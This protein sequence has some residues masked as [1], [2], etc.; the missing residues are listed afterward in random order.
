MAVRIITDSTADLVPEL[1]S[2]VTVVPM[3]ISFGP[4]EY[5]DGA[6]F[7]PRDFYEKLSCSPHHP[8][9]SQPAPAA[10]EDVFSQAVAAGDQ[11]VAITISREL[12]GTFQSAT[13]AA[14]AYPEE[15][16]VV[17][18]RTVAL[19]TG[20]LV[21]LALQLVDQGHTAPQI[22]QALTEA[23]ERLVILAMVDTL[24]YLKRGGRISKAAAVAGG[25]LSIKPIVGVEEGRLVVLGKARGSKQVGVLLE[26]LIRQAGGVDYSLPMVLG[27][28]G[29]DEGLLT[30]YLQ[31]HQ[32][33]WAPG[34]ERL[35]TTII[36]ATVGTHVGP[37]TLGIAFFR[38]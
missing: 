38:K 32:D 13:I 19:A 27:Y 33:L 23:R 9:T 30:K 5:T 36:G 10:F 18:S 17:D 15:V 8:T 37:G 20:A 26:K 25:L 2:R 31:N 34:G 12:S 3:T 16:Y 28:T 29:L 22:F 14:G 35:R 6:N 11:V 4:E 21:E 7:S 24:E 1:K